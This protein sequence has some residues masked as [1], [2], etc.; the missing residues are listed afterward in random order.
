MKAES[1]ILK[2][3]YDQLYDG[4]CGSTCA[5]FSELMTELAHVKTVAARGRPFA[6]PMQGVGGSKGQ[7]VLEFDA[8]LQAAHVAK[9]FAAQTGA[10]TDAV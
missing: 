2:L 1:Q 5:I 6:G 10:N 8:L 7:Q 9:M 4:L 3:A